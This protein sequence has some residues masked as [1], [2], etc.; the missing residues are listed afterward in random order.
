MGVVYC[1]H[2]LGTGRKVALKLLHT[3]VPGNE[4][5]EP[6]RFYREA[7]V[8]SELRHP[9]I[10]SYVAHGQTPEGQLYLAMEWLEG[11]DL[12][13]QLKHGP[14]SM[15]E[16]LTLCRPVADAL[17]AAHEKGIV[18]RDLKPSNLFL[19]DKLVERAT[20]FDF[21]IAHVARHGLSMTRTGV[22]VG[23]P[24]YMAPE[25]ARGDRT[26]QPATDVFALGCIFYACLTGKPPFSGDHVAAVLTKILFE[27]PPPLRQLV[28]NAPQAL[29]TLLLSMLAKDVAA[30]PQNAAELIPIFSELLEKVRGHSR[31]L[32]APQ[33][34]GLHAVEQQ[35]FSVVLAAPRPTR[36]GEDPFQKHAGLPTPTELIALQAE[37]ET[38]KVCFSA[39]ADGSLF[40]MA[41]PKNQATDQV[42][43]A[44][45]VALLLW[46]RWPGLDL[47]LTTGTGSRQASLGGPPGEVLDRAGRYLQR[48][49]EAHANRE[50]GILL[51]SVSAGLLDSSFDLRPSAQGPMLWGVRDENDETRLLLNKPSPCLGREQEIGVL[52]ALLSG[53]I[54]EEQAQAVLVSAPVG[55]GKTR[56]RREFARRAGLRDATVLHATGEAVLQKAPHALL[57]QLLR[58]HAGVSAR[59]N[60]TKQKDGLAA[61]WSPFPELAP[62][63]ETLFL[64]C[65]FQGGPP[66]PSALARQRAFVAWAKALCEKRPLLL[67]LDDFHW[68]D[69]M[70]A[71]VLDAVLF[72]LRERPFFVLALGRPEVEKLFPKLWSG[73]VQ[74]I[75]LGPLGR[76]ACE[77]L[78]LHALGK[79][80][81]PKTLSHLVGTSAGS[82]LFLEELIRSVAEG[83]GEQLPDTVLTIMQSRVLQLEPGARRVVCAASVFGTSFWRSG[84][85]ALL[86]LAPDFAE[87]AMDR[88]LQVLQDSEI[89][90]LQ[91]E[92][93][94]LLGPEY[95]F[96]SAALREAAYSLLTDEERQ[97]G[98]G[99]LSV[100][101]EQSGGS[102]PALLS[103]HTLQFVRFL[104]KNRSSLV[105]S[106]LMMLTG[107]P[108]RKNA[109]SF[110]DDPKALRRLRAGLRTL[111]EQD[112]L[113]DL[114]QLFQELA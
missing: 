70:S 60:E 80:V 68:A 34:R 69:A 86:G 101:L 111:L 58:R 42:R 2:D 85:C 112:E 16:T 64:L 43:E 77:R 45:R 96:R 87:N 84:L 67:L 36:P 114:P 91:S 52:E 56:L 107:L 88:W 37:L 100:Y 63:V 6:T 104:E 14:L 83:R 55:L 97:L 5:S 54:E 46:A 62:F 47:A 1:A 50:P 78:V 4:L 57:G 35:L 8:L 103:F 11:H 7:Q 74:D 95:S 24:E 18:H 25:Q 32:A 102:D 20:L 38:Q 90:S 79:D 15:T 10:V 49:H 82:P 13:Q 41:P 48:L 98:H 66:E 19:R 29:E 12:S 72:E 53:C 71:R 28:P 51:D 17:A 3:T 40:L 59:D 94:P 65:G 39:L 44:A 27:P 93:R 31:P 105:V 81:T 89:I 23:T 110:A 30:R 108:L 109:T 106:R 33:R 21:G 26:V 61:A 22:V 9:S 99:L 113:T 92:S 75:R 73:K 76:R